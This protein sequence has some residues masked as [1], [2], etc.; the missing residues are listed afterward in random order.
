M[1]TSGADGLSCSSFSSRIGGVVYFETK[2]AVVETMFAW[3]MV[4]RSG[5]TFPVFKSYQVRKGPLC[6]CSCAA[7]KVGIWAGYKGCFDGETSKCFKHSE[8][9]L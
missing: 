3:K 4:C 9:S 6:T 5:S 7:N 1:G 8:Y 2:S